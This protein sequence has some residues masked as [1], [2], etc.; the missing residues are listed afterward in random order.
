[1]KTNE[2]IGIDVSKLLI[3]VCIYSKQIVQQFENSKSGFKLM[4]KWCFKNSS[5]PKEET[6][7]VF[8]HTGMYSHLLSVFLARTKIKV[9]APSNHCG[10][11][12]CHG[13]DE[14]FCT[15]LNYTYGARRHHHA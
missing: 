11:G 10:L 14:F 5:F 7:F 9:E 3:D 8:E 13:Y 4:L 6:M 1:M 2:I 12:V 15:G